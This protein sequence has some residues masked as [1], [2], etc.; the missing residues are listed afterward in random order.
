MD[1]IG[2]FSKQE[3]TD[4]KMSF[5]CNG[6]FFNVS[7]LHV[8]RSVNL[9]KKGGG[10]RRNCHIPGLAGSVQFNASG[11]TVV[12][13]CFASVQDSWKTT[14]ASTLF[15]KGKGMELSLLIP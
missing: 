12:P 9:G 13:L 8:G 1:S 11:I 10:F 14:S 2:L 15:R 4:I 3:G 7:A 5:V 6:L